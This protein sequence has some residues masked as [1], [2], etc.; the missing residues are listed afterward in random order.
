MNE[1][2]TDKKKRGD[3]PHVKNS[4]HPFKSHKLLTYLFYLM[5]VTDG[6][7]VSYNLLYAP[8]SD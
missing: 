7:Q 2:C 3:R 4:S 6:L 8:H 5:V 1:N